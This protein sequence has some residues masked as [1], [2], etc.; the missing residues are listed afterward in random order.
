MSVFMLHFLLENRSMVSVTMKMF[1]N[2]NLSQKTND[3]KAKSLFDFIMSNCGVETSEALLYGYLL[4]L[5]PKAVSLVSP[6]I[7]TFISSLLVLFFHICIDYLSQPR[8][9]SPLVSL[10]LIFVSAAL[11]LDNLTMQWGN[12]Q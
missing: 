6:G 4:G 8:H 3:T 12:L 1:Q 9:K 2:K 10:W 5:Q 7:K 11:N